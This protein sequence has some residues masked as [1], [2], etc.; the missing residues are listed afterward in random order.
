MQM[1]TFLYDKQEVL[2]WIA[3]NNKQMIG[4]EFNSVFL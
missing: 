1:A 3:I 4:N 2:N